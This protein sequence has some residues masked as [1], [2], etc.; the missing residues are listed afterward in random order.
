MATD[1]RCGSVVYPTCWPVSTSVVVLAGRLPHI[2]GDGGCLPEESNPDA[3]GPA[4]KERRISVG[5]L[6]PQYLPA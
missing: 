5:R 4:F 1:E 3:M 6:F 2:I